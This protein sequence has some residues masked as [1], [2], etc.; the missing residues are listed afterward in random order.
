[1]TIY[2]K[3]FIY[4]LFDLAIKLT[5]LPAK[6]T[7]KVTW[8]PHPTK[9]SSTV[10]NCN[11]GNQVYSKTKLPLKKKLDETILPSM[12]SLNIINDDE[13]AVKGF[14]CLNWLVFVS[15]RTKVLLIKLIILQK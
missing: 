6:T 2:L 9:M 4:A 12:N 11:L 8:S 15:L 10:G 7:K 14:I 3:I 1:M 5:A 13:N